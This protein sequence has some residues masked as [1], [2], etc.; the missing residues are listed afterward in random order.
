[1]NP[2]LLPLALVVVVLVAGGIFLATRDIPA[3]RHAIQK[4]IGN[5]RFFK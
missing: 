3:P 4:V 2:R 5:D 1:M